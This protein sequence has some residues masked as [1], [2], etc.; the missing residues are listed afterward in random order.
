[1]KIKPRL[2]CSTMSVIIMSGCTIS[3]IP[4]QTPTQEPVIIAPTKVKPMTTATPLY[5]Q[6]VEIPKERWML[7]EDALAARLLSIPVERGA[8]YCE[9]EILGQDGQEV[10]LWA[11]CQVAGDPEGT[12]TS[13]PVVVT[14][15]NF[16]G[17]TRVDMPRDGTLYGEDIRTMFPA[18]LQNII[19]NQDVDVDSMWAHIQSR[20]ANPE[21]PLIE[22]AGSPL[23]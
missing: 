12:A 9:W 4:T 18:D 6:V 20:H 22:L 3:Q 23:P 10:Y 21:P 16:W 2:I 19:F 13:A 8:G 11:I 14:L 15:A 17:F 1:M 5:T 7:Y